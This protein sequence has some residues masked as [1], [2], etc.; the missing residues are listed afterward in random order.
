MPA[1]AAVGPVDLRPLRTRPLR[2][3]VLARRAPLPDLRP[4]RP[5]HPRR[6]PGLR[7]PADPARPQPGR[8]PICPACAGIV[9][10]VF[11]CRR[12]QREGR[13]YHHKLCIRCTLTDRVAALLDNGTG[14]IDP[15]LAPL[16]AALATGPTPTPAGRLV[17]LSKPHNRDLLRALATRT[18]PLTHDGADRLPRPSRHPLPARPARPLRRTA[19]SS[20]GNCSTSK[21]G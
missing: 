5:G 15:A 12:C 1:H 3:P 10:S 17:W 16:A 2:L 20:T 14:H 11:R 21:P 19:A 4:G 13:L 6:L 9:H 7:R 8:R 18:L